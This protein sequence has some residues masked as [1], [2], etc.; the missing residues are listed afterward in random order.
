MQVGQVEG[1]TPETS[2]GSDLLRGRNRPGQWNGFAM[3]HT[4]NMSLCAHNPIYYFYHI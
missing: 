1:S 2:A 4:Y 3:L